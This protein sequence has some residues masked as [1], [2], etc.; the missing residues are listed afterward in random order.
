MG[1]VMRV[2]AY[3]VIDIYLADSHYYEIGLVGYLENRYD[4]RTS[5]EPYDEECLLCVF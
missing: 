2:L 3:S 4:S 5:I 1:R